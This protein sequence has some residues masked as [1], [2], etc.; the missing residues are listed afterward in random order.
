MQRSPVPCNT[1][2]FAIRFPFREI[3]APFLLRVVH[4]LRFFLR[5]LFAPGDSRNS[6][7]RTSPSPRI[8][9]KHEIGGAAAVLGSIYNSGPTARRANLLFLKTSAANFHGNSLEDIYEREHGF[10][11]DRNARGYHLV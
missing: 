4:R 7:T 2:N 9:G 11:R 6:P 10:I 5:E 1:S 8:T 3:Y